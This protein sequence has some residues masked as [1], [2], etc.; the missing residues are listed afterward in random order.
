MQK[1]LKMLKNIVTHQLFIVVISS[2]IFGGLV[3]YLIFH[4][5]T[6]LEKRQ[7]KKQEEI[8]IIC[9]KETIRIINNI[10]QQQRK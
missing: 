4:L 2:V 10:V 8:R 9:E 1:I 6:T 3:C 7:L 5:P